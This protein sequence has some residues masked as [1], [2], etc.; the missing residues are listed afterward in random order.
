MTWF[1]LQTDTVIVALPAGRSKSGETPLPRPTIR[2]VVPSTV[3]A[4]LPAT[5]AEPSGAADALPA[6]P[7]G[8]CGRCR[9]EAG[10]R[11]RFARRERHEEDDRDDGG[12]QPAR[13]AEPAPD[14]VFPML[15]SVIH[16]S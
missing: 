11:A 8:R 1:D 6:G 9:G 14:R 3:T 2:T 16:S 5:G 12:G 10:W 4:G 13:R 7:V 15:A